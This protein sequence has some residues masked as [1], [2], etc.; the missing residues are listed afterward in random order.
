[1][2]VR[3]LV[4]VPK[5]QRIDKRGNIAK[6]DILEFRDFSELAQN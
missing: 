4:G 6:R 2:P 5:H 1:M 3:L